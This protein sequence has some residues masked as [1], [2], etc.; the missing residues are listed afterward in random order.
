[1][2]D[3]DKKIL[4]ISVVLITLVG[5][6]LSLN[7]FKQI[8]INDVS[9]SSTDFD[10]TPAPPNENFTWGIN[11]GD[12]FGW[13]IEQYIN[14]SLY[15]ENDL[16]FN[17]TNFLFDKWF[18]FEDEKYYYGVEMNLMEWNNSLSAF[19]TAMPAYSEI[20]INT[21]T[22]MI[23]FT[24]NEIISG[25]M[26]FYVPPFIP[27]NGSTLAIDWCAN[28]FNHTL[29]GTIFHVDGNSFKI[30]HNITIA[31]VEI[32]ANYT[33]D[34]ILEFA[35][36]KFNYTEM[37]FGTQKVLYSRLSDLNPYAGIEWAI[38]E[39]DE[40]YMN[41]A[42]AA[43][44]FEIIDIYNIS[45]LN[46]LT[47][48]PIHIQTVNASWS[49]WDDMMNS[50][51]T[52]EDNV[53]IGAASKYKPLIPELEP[54]IEGNLPQFLIIPM[55]F[56]GKE[57][58][59]SFNSLNSPFFHPPFL[60][61]IEHGDLWVRCREESTGETLYLEYI[62]STGFL[63]EM[64]NYINE[65]EVIIFYENSAIL[66]AGNHNKMIEV[67]KLVESDF[68]V[69][70]RLGVTDRTQLLTGSS[71]V[72]PFSVDLENGKIFIDIMLND[73]NNLDT[74]LSGALNI[75]IEY[76]NLRFNKRTIEIW[77]YNSEGMWTPVPY[78]DLCDGKILIST[79]DIFA[80][81][82]AVTEF[83]Q[84]DPNSV[85]FEDME[86]KYAYEDEMYYYFPK[87]LNIRY[88]GKAPFI[89]E[90]INELEG[91]EMPY[92][93]PSWT[94]NT[95]TR[96]IS[97][98][99]FYN[100]F[101]S[102]IHTPVWIFTNISLGDL[103]PIG[104]M[105][106]DKT[107]NVSGEGSQ[108]VYGVGN[109]DVWVL[110][111]LSQPGVYLY[112]E[113][114]T[115]LLIN[116][117]FKA[118]HPYYQET[119]EGKF[120]LIE[121]NAEMEGTLP[122]NDQIVSL[123][124]PKYI[125]LGESYLV[126]ATVENWGEPSESLID[127]YLYLNGAEVGSITISSLESWETV[128]ISYNWTPSSYGTYNFTA[129]APAVPEEEKT[130]NNLKTRLLDVKQAQIFDGMQLE[131]NFFQF[132][133]MYPEGSPSMRLLVNYTKETKSKYNENIGQ[134]NGTDYMY[135]LPYWV[136]V[137]TRE[138]C[139]Q[140]M[141][142]GYGIGES[143]T[144]FWIHNDTS[145]G[146][147]IELGFPS[148]YETWMYNV[149][150][151]RIHSLHGFGDIN[152]WELESLSDPG[153]YLWYEKETG[154]LTNGSICFTSMG[155]NGSFYF[156]LFYTNALELLELIWTPEPT[157]I[158]HCRYHPYY[159]F[160]LTF[161]HRFSAKSPVGIDQYWINDTDNFKIDSSTG[162]LTANTILDYKVY[163]LKIGVN[164]S[165][166]NSLEKVITV[167]GYPYPQWD[168]RPE[169][170]VLMHG[171][172]FS[173]DVDLKY[174]YSGD[175]YSIDD[176]ENF[177]IDSKTGLITNNT[178]LKPGTYPLYITAYR[179]IGT[180]GYIYPSMSA[181]ANIVIKVIN[182]TDIS[183]QEATMIP[184]VQWDEDW[185]R[186]GA[187]SEELILT[188]NL[189]FDEFEGDMDIDLFYK[190]GYIMYGEEM[191]FGKTFTRILPENGTYY[192]CVSGYNVGNNYSLWWATSTTPPDDN[193]EEN[194]ELGSAFDL[195][196]YEG[197]WLSSINQTGVQMDEDWYEIYVAQGELNL[198]VE[199]LYNDSDNHINIVLRDEKGSW[200]KSS[201]WSGNGKAIKDILPNNGTYYLEVYGD[202]MA[203]TYDLRWVTSLTPPDDNY[204]ENDNLDSAFDLSAFEGVWLSNI[205]LT[206]VQMDEDWYEI[207]VAPGELNL[208]LELLFNDSINYINIAL[209]SSD[210]SWIYGDSWWWIYEMRIEEFVPE[211]GVY[212]LRVCGD[213]MADTYDLRWY[214][215]ERLEDNYEENDF[216]TLSYDLSQ[217]EGVW[218]SDIDGTGIQR[219]QDLFEIS[220]NPSEP[221][222]SVR[223]IFN[224]S[225]GNMG[226]HLIKESDSFPVASCFSMSD[227]ATVYCYA[228]SGGTFII[229]IL[230]ENKGNEYDLR[231]DTT[232]VPPPDDNYE[233]ND[234]VPFNLT[235]Y[236][237]TW[238]ND[239]DGLGIQRDTDIFEISMKPS[240]P[241]LKVDLFF[242]H[243]EGNMDLGLTN[244]S[245]FFPLAYEFSMT[246]NETIYYYAPN[247]GTFWIHIF[248]DN[249]GN[250]YDLLW[251]CSNQPLE[252]IPPTWTPEPTHQV[253]IKG[254][255]L[256]YDIDASDPTGI[257]TFWLNDT[258]IFEISPD[259][260]LYNTTT[261]P[262]GKYWLTVFVNDTFS[263]INSKAIMIYVQDP[264]APTI[265]I[266]IPKLED[267]VGFLAPTYSIHVSDSN[268]DTMWY[269][270]NGGE[271][272]IFTA[273][274]TIDQTIWNS[275]NDGS[276]TIYFFANDTE[277]HIG[278]NTIIIEKDTTAPT[279]TIHN[280]SSNDLLGPNAPFLSLNSFDPNGIHSEW[281]SLNGIKNYTYTP[282]NQEAWNSV[283]DGILT[284][285]FYANDTLGNTAEISINIIKDTAV[286][287]IIIIKPAQNEVYGDLASSFSVEVIDTHLEDMWYCL[288]GGENITFT[289][290]GTISQG[291]WNIIADGNVT[292][293]F[294]ANDTL[295]NTAEISINII[296]DTAVP[297]I[298]IIKPAQNE[299]YGDLA[300]SFSVEVIDTHLEDMWYCLN[301]GEN[302]TFTS[303]GTISQGAWNIIADGNVTIT[304]Y[305]N[306]TVGLIGMYST[307]IVK[308]TTAPTIDI[309]QP[310]QNEVYGALA[311][312]FFVEITDTHLEDMWYCL[313]G[314]ENI[315]FTSNGSLN[316]AIWE[317]LIDS[318]YTIV[319]YA[320]DTRGNIGSDSV[321]LIKDTVAPT[322]NVLSPQG[323]QTFGNTAPRYSIQV[324]DP[325]I[326][327]IWYSINGGQNITATALNGTI[328]QAIWAS[329]S[330]G[331]VTITFYANDTAGNV[332]SCSV[333]VYKTDADSGGE[334]IPSY[335][336]II[337]M[338]I[339][340]L[341]T[342]S[343]ARV[344]KRKIRI[345]QE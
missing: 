197:T 81:G 102:G 338:P 236:E 150:G 29:N 181:Y 326:D 31:F 18:D 57:L 336:L 229:Y 22:S 127:L 82:F 69:S 106:T 191:E 253:I 264:L 23:N 129:Y 257:D 265:N 33:D 332:A 235:F 74:R 19:Q 218:L 10:P 186:F 144:P 28:A 224:Y 183:Q 140:Q 286:P 263:N 12:K 3:K 157:D 93:N 70:L 112:Y 217:Y 160:D 72:N 97:N 108:F 246:D 319:F 98:S 48:F 96:L 310:A 1:M 211:S 101:S 198:T 46:Y 301:G 167:T 333:D 122:A 272:I 298:I 11:K 58:K 228:P 168:T 125:E 151:E 280:P 147:H 307:D 113:K 25:G 16:F 43:S 49:I 40:L 196:A 321:D 318:N 206:G 163:W 105:G 66:S 76:N 327:K 205:N 320:N 95:Q 251:N 103:V 288:N 44:K 249:R 207:Y 335:L 302:I 188:V 99:Y 77:R 314:G 130:D 290:N 328:N 143:F 292:I 305:A 2:K 241:Y 6:L 260:L 165:I 115:G 132:S 294:Y 192:L 200:I 17:V 329:T 289:S 254:D 313:N 170:Q 39:G 180:Y 231:W 220:V 306:D 73:S 26:Y 262:V 330:N 176:T 345:E 258:S 21:N 291:A 274:G 53:I 51:E 238:L 148:F 341:I 193:Y 152:V 281:Y 189:F 278:L 55:G 279:L 15:F 293:T 114:D 24:N 84:S 325:Y 137:N 185:Y 121:T 273:N 256:S 203:D 116:G 107:Y 123:E 266:S 161:R 312:S 177:A 169:D 344:V 14:Q 214:T 124:F 202:D 65:G 134:Y 316:Q 297:S 128:E 162:E 41:M 208:T 275:L 126:N 201:S 179:Y 267:V 71:L 308:D 209:Y 131:Y 78:T 158:G 230:G 323:N 276:V 35:E 285:T 32:Q 212:Y 45:T 216:H 62:K 47:P 142:M 271:E 104:I 311:P 270:V 300:S 61:S 37:P 20:P 175:I 109:V 295:G 133:S 233:E 248:G 283:S 284:I 13:K 334:E 199:L 9:V 63:K 155:F 56:T 30:T 92:T 304:F 83:F 232:A 171:T 243:S 5:V 322:I 87:F 247:G 340:V 42:G 195:S 117:T 222:V 252:T 282:Y 190:N 215:S 94:I 159:P 268:L 118:S 110:E 244:C 210:G 138:E 226:F 119:V 75:T 184:G 182:A 141:G 8:N 86:V 146:D 80:F 27:L 60:N 339:V 7:A 52:H 64:A 120:E 245:H 261:I 50:W 324:S 287:S 68:N 111:D 166:G 223:L 269:T 173:Y 135:I 299:V 342:L 237:N 79:D 38:K 89:F 213:D 136:D 145:L 85:L 153:V 4:F 204:E 303:N 156:D 277:G 149:S 227:N 91:M 250:T 331:T 139:F 34:G 100:L 240:E 309:T 343:L 242:E 164:D 154:I 194:D 296:K 178:I 259:G 59:K 219:D 187:T 234:F 239:V 172:P 225:E 36:I 315:T 67:S 88:Q 90:G 317:S 174:N 54:G 221:Y 337:V 255:S